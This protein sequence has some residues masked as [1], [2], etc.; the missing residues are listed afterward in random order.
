[1]ENA[2]KVLVVDDE[3]TILNMVSE[4]LSDAGYQV[5]QANS[6]QTAARAFLNCP[7][8]VV[9]T[10]I[11]MESE[12]S[13]VQL[14]RL[15]KQVE[16]DSQVILM[17]A[18]ANSECM[19]EAIRANAFDF[20]LKPFDDIDRVTNVVHR[21]IE[22]WQLIQDNIIA[23]DKIRI[24]KQQLE[25]DNRALQEQ[26][27]HDGDNDVYNREF[28]AEVIESETARAIRYERHYSIIMTTL[29]HHCENA[30][31]QLLIRSKLKEATQH[32]KD[33]LR[34]SDIFAHYEGS[35]Y[36][37]LLPETD[38]KGALILANR[39]RDKIEESSHVKYQ[40]D[41]TELKISISLASASFPED[42]NECSILMHALERTTEQFSAKS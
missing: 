26:S 41:R 13:G 6:A 25:H 3:K 11:R 31:D 23:M 34:N 29:E 1:M 12:M 42:G 17:T 8:P 30:A 36:I 19:L 15:I 24:E 37:I 33:L 40:Q 14:L 39:I 4:V 9:I 22:K 38:K 32:I 28:I 16:P 35:K 2:I 20:L 5:M 18:Y 27:V 10:D 7:C 21:A